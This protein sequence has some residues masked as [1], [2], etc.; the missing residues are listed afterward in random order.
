MTETLIDLPLVPDPDPDDE[1]GASEV[2]SIS[3]AELRDCRLLVTRRAAQT[4]DAAG[5]R[6]GLLKLGCSFQPTHGTRFV[7]ARVVLSIAAP[8]GTRIVDVAPAAQL[9]ERPVKFVVDVQGK[10]R[11]QYAA[12]G[13]EAG[14]E[15]KTSTS[16]DV[17]YCSVHGT[18]A[19]TAKGR[20]E[21]EENPRRR[22][23][24]A[25]EQP[26]VVTFSESGRYRG[27]LSVYAK[28]VRGG[29]MGA[30]DAFR[31]MLLGADE[32]HAPFAV[33]IPP[34]LELELE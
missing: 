6:Y 29:T 24:L 14:M 12:S 23:G 19:G 34:L 17:Y 32:H 1:L 31:Y 7:W 27:N 8:E 2:C 9:D 28:I 26:L 10:L 18:G 13:L 11:A 22:D 4:I 30:I 33:D 25:R 3:D 5:T 15:S 16:F 20:W 21:F